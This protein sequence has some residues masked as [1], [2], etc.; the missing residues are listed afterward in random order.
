M[1]SS[2]RIHPITKKHTRALRGSLTDAE[3]R[4]WSILRQRQLGGFKFRRQHPLGNYIL[5][6]VCLE[7][8]LVIEVD[9]SQHLEQHGQDSKRTK[10]LNER[11]YRVLRFWNNEVLQNTPAVREAI[12]QVLSFGEPPP[13]QP[14]P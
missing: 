11:G 14:S 8:R 9:G 7:A 4:L 2:T 3:Q 10:W 1:T 6:F 12:W 5:D 13:F